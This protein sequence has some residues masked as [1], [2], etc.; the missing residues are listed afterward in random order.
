LSAAIR[1]PVFR[2]TAPVP[3]HHAPFANLAEIKRE[4]LMSREARARWV[5]PDPKPFEWTIVFV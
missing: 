2:M 1:V 5:E 3:N 4:H